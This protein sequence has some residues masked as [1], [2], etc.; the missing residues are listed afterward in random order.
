MLYY[1]AI[2]VG[3][4]KSLKFYERLKCFSRMF[5]KLPFPNL[6]DLML[7][8]FACNAKKRSKCA[9]FESII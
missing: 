5:R 3:F 7:S 2:F 6:I 4:I 1:N 9:S 8:M